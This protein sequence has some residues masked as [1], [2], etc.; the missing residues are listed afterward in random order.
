MEP[1]EADPNGNDDNDDEGVSVTANEEEEEEV[2][3]FL[4]SEDADSKRGLGSTTPVVVLLARAHSGEA[5]TSFVVQGFIDFLL[6]HHEIAE[7][8][9]KHVIFKVCTVYSTTD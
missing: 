5:P 9:R 8:L 4:N 7:D 3:R 6:S 2:D 1:E